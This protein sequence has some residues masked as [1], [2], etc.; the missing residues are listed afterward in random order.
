MKDDATELLPRRARLMTAAIIGA[1][2]IH[3]PIAAKPQQNIFID[4]IG[5][6]PAKIVYSCEQSI[7]DGGHESFYDEEWEMFSDCVNSEM[8]RR[9]LKKNKR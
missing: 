7:G 5:R 8:S 1:L 9:Q 4:G 6:V 3:A 2:W